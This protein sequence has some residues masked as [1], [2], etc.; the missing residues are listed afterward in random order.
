MR[1]IAGWRRGRTAA[2]PRQ[3]HRG[4]RTGTIWLKSTSD[5]VYVTIVVIGHWLMKKFW[6]LV[7]GCVLRT[8]GTLTIYILNKSVM[9]LYLVFK[10]LYGEL[11]EK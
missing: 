6:P 4:A 2:H 5:V 1:G 8:A 11:N 9:F 3:V 10:L 7:L